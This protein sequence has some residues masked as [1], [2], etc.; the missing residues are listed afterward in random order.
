[1]IQIIFQISI[2]I[3][4]IVYSCIFGKCDAWYWYYGNQCKYTLK[5]KLMDLHNP[6]LSAMMKIEADDVIEQPK[7]TMDKSKFLS[8]YTQDLL[9]NSIPNVDNWLINVFTNL[10][11]SKK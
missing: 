1:M 9:G 4:W 8:M 3:S 2:L 6:N 7:S 11:A 5:E 10:L